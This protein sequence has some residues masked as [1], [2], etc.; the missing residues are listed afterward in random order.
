YLW[1]YHDII[2]PIIIVNFYFHMPDAVL[3]QQSSTPM[4]DR[5]N[6]ISATA[7]SQYVHLTE[8]ARYWWLRRHPAERQALRAHF[9]DL[10]VDEQPL[11]P[12]LRNAGQEFE[13][14]VLHGVPGVQ[15]NLQKQD[16]TATR[17]A[18]AALHPG[19]GCVLLQPEVAGVLGGQPCVGRA[20][21]V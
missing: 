3:L 13:Q 10:A 9:R 17:Q 6:P 14:A 20:D 15:H 7:V 11:T 21:V 8:C 16:S 4:T 18:L 1:T 12:L 2:P 5:A 19:M